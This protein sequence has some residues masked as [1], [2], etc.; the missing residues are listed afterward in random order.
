MFQTN[1]LDRM[2]RDIDLRFGWKRGVLLTD[3]QTDKGETR[4]YCRHF[5]LNIFFFKPPGPEESF[6]IP[7][8]TQQRQ[9]KGPTMA[10][11][12]SNGKYMDCQ[13]LFEEAG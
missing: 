12:A 2:M 5:F 13:A 11:T 9:Q 8:L 1:P 4:D 7:T 10:D 6:T 3:G